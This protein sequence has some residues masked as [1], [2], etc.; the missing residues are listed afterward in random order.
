M[1]YGLTAHPRREAFERVVQA[2]I[3][4]F[5]VKAATIVVRQ[6]LLIK[7]RLYDF[8]LS[9]EDAG[10]VWSL[11][12]AVVLGPPLRLSRE[13]RLAALAAP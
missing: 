1:F 2:L 12:I 11:I 13:Q 5:I 10:L 9:G 4:T 7:T 3:F 6:K 8:G